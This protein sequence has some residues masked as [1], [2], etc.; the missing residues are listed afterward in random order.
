MFH[1][2]VGLRMLLGWTIAQLPQAEAFNRPSA[3]PVTV[4]A[5]QYDGQLLTA[6]CGGSWTSESR[7]GDVELSTLKL[8]KSYV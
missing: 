4:G 5:T 2:A 1:P 7:C 8:E 6:L 3:Q